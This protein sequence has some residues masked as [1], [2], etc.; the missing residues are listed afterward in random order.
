MN[1]NVKIL[2][3]REICNLLI[4]K[5]GIKIHDGHYQDS[6]VPPLDEYSSYFELQV[7]DYEMW[8]EPLEIFIRVRVTSQNMAADEVMHHD[9][10]YSSPI[11]FSLLG[12]QK[13]ISQSL[14]VRWRNRSNSELWN[15]GRSDFKARLL[16]SS[17]TYY[18]VMSLLYFCLCSRWF[19]YQIQETSSKTN[20][21]KFP[22]MFSFRSFIA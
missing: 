22:T 1:K 21:M 16:K 11:S 18:N 15:M 9:T 4:F 5:K 8:L 19:G 10:H 20:A 13:T 17:M 6:V 3:F 14:V 7:A 12:T 2:F